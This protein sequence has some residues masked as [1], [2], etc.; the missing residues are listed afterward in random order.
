MKF[1]D[2]ANIINFHKAHPNVSLEHHVRQKC[3]QL[4]EEV[5]KKY[6]I[7]LDLRFWILLRNVEL[8]RN[9]DRA[10][11]ELLKK[12]K[13][14]VDN[15][16]AICPISESIFIEVMKQSDPVTRVATSELI[17]RLSK[18]ISLITHRQ[19]ISQELCN[20][21]YSQAGAHDL[22]PLDI[23]V[24][25]KL[26]YVLGEAHPY[27]TS[28]D[29]K[30]ELVIKKSFF[31]HMWS[32]SLAEMVGYLDFES[33]HQPAWQNTADFI[34]ESNKKYANEMKSF[35]QIYLDEFEGGLSLFRDE[36]LMLFREVDS[37]GYKDSKRESESLTKSERFSNF[38]K[39]IRTL[40][41]GACC[42]AA[43]RWDQ[44]R[45]LTGNDLLDFHHAEAAIGYCNLF[46]TEKPLKALVSLRHLG[47]LSDYSCTVVS[48]AKEAFQALSGV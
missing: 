6:R 13:Y 47:L 46:L 17:D 7:Y 11:I 28:F 42:H 5:S 20:A 22:Y 8:G 12:L 39:S 33:W 34:N 41:I 21:I 36:L 4:G 45:Q 27:R 44:K 37:K 10:L 32:I 9:E 18:G 24:W 40:H 26:A 16:T 48:T 23:L 31:D 1:N 3:I 43:V 19:R 29:A 38:S 30:H 15:E 35:K 14:L 2:V 25:I